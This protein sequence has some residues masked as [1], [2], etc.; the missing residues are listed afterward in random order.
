MSLQVLSAQDSHET[1]DPDIGKTGR[2]DS[3]TRYTWLHAEQ[4]LRAN[5]RSEAWIGNTELSSDRIGAINNPNIAI[6]Q[7][8]DYRRANIWDA[9]LRFYGP[10]G[11]AHQLEWGVNWSAADA[12][13][14]Y[15]SAVNFGTGVA[16]LFARPTT[17]VGDALLSPYRRDTSVYVSDRWQI[18]PRLVAE[19]GVRTQ[20]A[21]GL[22]LAPHDSQDPRLLM[23]FA[24][25]ST[26]QMFASWGV[27]HQ[28]DEVLDLDVTD[29]LRRFSPP[30]RSE[31]RILGIQYHSSEGITLRAEAY[32]KA[33]T[34]PRRRYESY[35]DPLGALP[36]LTPDRVLVAPTHSEMHGVEL[37]SAFAKGAFSTRLSYGW[38]RVYDDIRGM[39]VPRSWN[40]AHTIDAIVQWQRGLWSAS[41][42]LNV[43]S[44]WPTTPLLTLP[45]GNA[46]LAARNSSTESLFQSLD[47]RM[48]YHQN[49]QHGALVY[50]VDVANALNHDNHCCADIVRSKT[51]PG[52]N[53]LSVQESLPWLPR[54]PSFG[55]RWEF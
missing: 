7:V 26:T 40:Q 47:L 44:G 3:R 21:C 42:A 37:S 35:F 45:G 32:R 46:Q 50:T 8:S 24:L 51:S 34:S 28:A 11:S 2:F 53:S 39:D 22:E 54:I 1:L 43:H 31:H 15:H 6:G 5:W 29:G 25:R 41:A 52:A 55:V 13:Y 18:L 14:K 10:L 16:Q 20:H 9:Q 30:Q 49:I 4:Y 17:V 27:F 36:E 48:V 19:I 33:Q 38:S 23:S 12:D